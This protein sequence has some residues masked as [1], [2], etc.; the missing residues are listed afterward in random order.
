M[1]TWGIR[2][3]YLI[4]KWLRVTKSFFLHQNSLTI[5]LFFENNIK[6]V[7]G[8]RMKHFPYDTRNPQLFK[9]IY[10]VQ[11]EKQMKELCLVE[12]GKFSSLRS[13]DLSST[14]RP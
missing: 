7:N 10:I 13:P 5:A 6:N 4:I 8:P 2:L 11:N 9:D 12:I 14:F 1:D 3:C